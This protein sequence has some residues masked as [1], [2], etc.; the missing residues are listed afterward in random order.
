MRWCSPFRDRYGT[1]MLHR[2]YHGWGRFHSS[3]ITMVSR[4]CRC[5][6]VTLMSVRVASRPLHPSYGQVLGTDLSGDAILNVLGFL[7]HLTCIPP[8]PSSL[9]PCRDG[10]G[11]AQ[12]VTPSTSCSRTPESAPAPAASPCSSIPTRYPPCVGFFCPH[13]NHPSWLAHHPHGFPN[14]FLQSHPVKYPCQR[15]KRIL[16]L[17]Q[18]GGGHHPVVCL[19]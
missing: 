5:Q 12:P 4:T 18:V 13:P 3:S 10:F 17:P 19:E 6:K 16:G 11:G 7:P 1:S 2:G 14:V 9:L 8:A 15:I